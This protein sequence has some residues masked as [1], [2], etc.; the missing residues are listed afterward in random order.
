MNDMDDNPNI[1]KEKKRDNLPCG[2]RNT[3]CNFSLS[4]IFIHITPRSAA[5][6]ALANCV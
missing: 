3:L 6:H 2:E 1:D 5:L 4:I